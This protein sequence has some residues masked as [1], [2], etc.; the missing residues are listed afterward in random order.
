LRRFG[1]PERRHLKGVLGCQSVTGIGASSSPKLRLL[2]RCRSTSVFGAHRLCA[3]S[4]NCQRRIRWGVEDRFQA[5]SPCVG[6]TYEWGSRPSPRL[7]AFDHTGVGGLCTLGLIGSRNDMAQISLRR[8]SAKTRSDGVTPTRASIMEQADILPYDSGVRSDGRMLPCKLSS[9]D[10]FK[11]RRWFYNCESQSAS[12]AANLRADRA[13]QRGLI[14]DQPSFFTRQRRFEQRGIFPTLGRPTMARGE[15]H[16]T[17]PKKLDQACRLA[18]LQPNG[19]A[20]QL[21]FRG[22]DVQNAHKQRPV[23]VVAPPREYRPVRPVP[24]LVSDQSCGSL[25]SA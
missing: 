21:P 18:Y 11:S 20:V 3:A 22:Y 14:I 19:K 5:A 9:V 25:P 16:G 2:L 24:R 8:M 6:Q 15:G 4:A 7:Y 1:A 12:R 17:A 10:F 23:A 13:S